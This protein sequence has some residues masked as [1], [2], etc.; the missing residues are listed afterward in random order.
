MAAHDPFLSLEPLQFQGPVPERNGHSL[1]RSET[2]HPSSAI[3]D[4]VSASV[5]REQA[6]YFHRLGVPRVLMTST[7]RTAQCG[8]ACR[9]V[10][11]GG[12]V[13]LTTPPMSIL[14]TFECSR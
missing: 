10:S 1:R 8:P 2:C 7:T 11:A 5:G 13:A 4:T 12:Q 6:A 9:V 14:P 3:L